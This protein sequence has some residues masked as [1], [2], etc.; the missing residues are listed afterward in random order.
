M[1][2]EI[3]LV[4]IYF[5]PLLN[6]GLS[7]RAQKAS[8]DTKMDNYKV[9]VYIVFKKNLHFAGVLT[10]YYDFILQI[11]Q[12]LGKGAQGS[13]LLVENKANG[14]RVVLKKVCLY[15]FCSR[16]RLSSARFDDFH[17]FNIDSRSSNISI[18]FI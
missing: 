6:V 10:K 14:T 5:V 3:L 18:S 7:L 9:C 17:G 15:W 13:A 2:N 8:L 16:L 4:R 12:K 1:H 11:I